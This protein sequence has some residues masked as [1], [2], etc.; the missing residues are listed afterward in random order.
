MRLLTYIRTALTCDP[1]DIQV[2]PDVD[3]A[4]KYNQ[5]IAEL[6]LTTNLIVFEVTNASGRVHGIAACSLEK[7]W[8]E[9]EWDVVLLQ[10]INVITAGRHGV[11][12]L[13]LSRVE[14]FAKQ[15]YAHVRGMG[16]EPRVQH[17][18]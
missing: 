3:S 2:R 1:C 9:S 14:R 11:G 15:S 17:D 12:A 16:L 13:L 6:E 4:T 7:S 5:A 8:K 18:I 10:E